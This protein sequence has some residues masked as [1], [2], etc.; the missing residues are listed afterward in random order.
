MEETLILVDDNDN[1]IGNASRDECHRGKG[2]RHRAFIIFLFDSKGRVLLQFRNK[3][4][5]GGERWDAS[6]ISHVR[7]GETYET[8]AE[9]SMKYELG[10]SVPVKKISGF[11][12]TEPYDGYSENEYCLVLVG[13]YDGEINLN[14]KEVDKV[15]YS[16]LNEIKQ[17]MDKNSK[18]YTKWFREAFPILYEFVES[19]SLED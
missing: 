18:Q 11:T 4:K 9:R 2:R 5:L 6:A 3:S 12:Y 8:A 15:K 7:Q 17:D 19:D 16:T 13:K 1:Q 14:K 10:I